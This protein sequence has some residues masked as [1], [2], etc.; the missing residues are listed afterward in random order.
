MC[1]VSVNTRSNRQ[2]YVEEIDKSSASVLKESCGA[3]T[4]KS[5]SSA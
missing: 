1:N 2:F 4:D 5:S 3:E